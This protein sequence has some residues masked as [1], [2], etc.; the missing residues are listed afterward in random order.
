LTMS[1]TRLSRRTHVMPQNNFST[2]FKPEHPWSNDS[3]PLTS[4]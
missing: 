2:D 4:F 1:N 3:F